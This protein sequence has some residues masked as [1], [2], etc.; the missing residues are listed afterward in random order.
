MNKLLFLVVIVALYC[1]GCALAAGAV[2]GSLAGTL[3]GSSLELGSSD[4]RPDC[5][6]CIRLPEG[7]KKEQYEELLRRQQMILNQTNR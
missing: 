6:S 1:S 3:I 4:S 7:M 5:P 2:A